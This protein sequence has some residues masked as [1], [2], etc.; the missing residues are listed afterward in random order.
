MRK[1]WGC[2]ALVCVLMLSSGA[3]AESDVFVI[4]ADALD[5]SRLGDSDYVQQV[6]TAAT[7]YIRVI[8]TLGEEARQVTLSI[9][10]QDDG[11][12]IYQKNYG[13]ISG[14]FSSGDIYLKYAGS[15]TVGYE[16]TLMAGERKW[17]FPFYREL[18]LLSHNTACTYGIRVRDAAPWLT[19]GWT[20]ATVVDLEALAA[21]GSQSV[22]LCASNMY[23]IGTVEI[24]LT[25]GS[26][27]VTVEPLENI[28]LTIHKQRLYAITD[29][30]ALAGLGRKALK[31]LKAFQP[32]D[33][34]DMAEDLYESKYV[35][36][37]LPMEISY[38]PNGLE[39][40]SYS[41]DEMTD[42][43]EG[44]Q[45]LMANSAVEAVG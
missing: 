26:L 24:R 14:E 12:V 45:Y 13:E 18:M 32:G 38:D 10:R 7:Q 6:L 23:I 42:Q 44:W 20:M 1:V 39:Q 25:E 19:D 30:G 35:I 41:A 40:F 8:C 3:L 36:L 29:P 4:E 15:E 31:S 34:I 5:M 27:M 28:Q 16:I 9:T 11:Q 22:L 2:L 21:Q 33:A 17:V 43:L 37:Y